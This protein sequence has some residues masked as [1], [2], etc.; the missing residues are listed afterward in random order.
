MRFGAVFLSFLLIPFALFAEG[1]STRTGFVDGPVWFSEESL[2]LGQTVKLYTAIFNGEDSK[3]ILKVDFIDD[4]TA[5][6]TKEII[7]N[8]NETKTVSIDWKVS[9]GSHEIFAVISSSKK[10]EENII[11]ERVKTQPVKFSVTQD[12]PGGVVKNA[13]TNKFSSIFEGDKNFLQKADILFKI[14]FAKSEEWREEK[15]VDFKNSKEKVEKRREGDKDAKTSVKVISLIHFYSLTAIYFI[16]S[17]SVIFYLLAVILAYLSL[18]TI[19]RILKRIF[20]K[21]YEE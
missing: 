5:L 4:T 7:I 16:F 2:K 19:W 9:S 11:L 1:I 17:V 13:I 20:R 12:V 3:I 8:P 6:S 10:S 18:R 15:L 21:K 14:N